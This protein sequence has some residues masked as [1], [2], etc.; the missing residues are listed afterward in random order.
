MKV[1]VKDGQ[2]LADVAVQEYGVWEAVVDLAMENDVPMTDVPEAGTELSLP[3]VTMSVLMQDYCRTNDVSPAT[4]R[5]QG[6]IQLRVF[7]Q[8]FTQQFT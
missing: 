1:H 5:D 6:D 8:E 3:D 7:T 2:W 4:A